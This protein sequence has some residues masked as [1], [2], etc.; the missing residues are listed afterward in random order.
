MPNDRPRVGPMSPPAVF[1]DRLK[2]KGATRPES[3]DDSIRRFCKAPPKPKSA[4]LVQ[5]V[6]LP[7][8]GKSTTIKLVFR[9]LVKAGYLAYPMNNSAL[10]IFRDLKDL[11]DGVQLPAIARLVQYAG[12]LRVQLAEIQKLRFQFNVILAEHYSD[13]FRAFESLA[14]HDPQ[15]ARVVANALRGVPRAD[16]TFYLSAPP[17]LAIERHKGRLTAEDFIRMYHSLES[18]AVPESWHR[19]PVLGR[20][21]DDIAEEC[22]R[23]IVDRLN[24]RFYM[25]ATAAKRARTDPGRY[26]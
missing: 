7:D 24:A 25:R 4:L 21:E 10:P 15:A 9:K 8:I 3:P 6:A 17:S 2:R 20:G 12:I 22:L 26:V 14:D 13:F 16:L 1:N 19:I 23:V 5:M 18:R 11:S